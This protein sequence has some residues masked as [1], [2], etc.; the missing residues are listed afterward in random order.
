MSWIGLFQAIASGSF[1]LIGAGGCHHHLADIVDV[2]EGLAL[3]GFGDGVEGRTYIIAGSAPVRVRDLVQMIGEEVGV[4]S[5][6]TSLR[7]GPFRLYRILNACVYAWRGYRL[8]RADRIDFFLG[9]RVFDISRGRQELG[10]APKVH[11]REAVR[12]TAEWFREH[13]YLMPF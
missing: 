10:Y 3:R 13:G 6:P 12:R 1:R 7:V 5:F 9:D 2:V 11:T 4:T 8:P